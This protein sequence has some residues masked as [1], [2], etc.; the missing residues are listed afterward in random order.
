MLAELVVAPGVLKAAYSSGWAGLTNCTPVPSAVCPWF[1]PFG[2][3]TRKPLFVHA[4]L[5]QEKFASGAGVGATVGV[6]AVVGVG[7][8]VGVGLGMAVGDGAA[9]GATVG[10]AAA[11]GE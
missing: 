3:S 6:G 8:T 5:H 9:V 7:A 11:L 10:V 1:H 2:N 4:V